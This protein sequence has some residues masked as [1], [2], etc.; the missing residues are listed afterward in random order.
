ML[1][2]GSLLFALWALPAAAA[3]ADIRWIHDYA[4]GKA[5]SKDTGKPMVILFGVGSNGGSC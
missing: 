1:R 5:A 4:A 2:T 3:W